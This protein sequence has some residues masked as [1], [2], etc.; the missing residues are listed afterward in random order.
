MFVLLTCCGDAQLL[1]RVALNLYNFM[2]GE[3][4]SQ[5]TYNIMKSVGI[6]LI[7]LCILNF[8][9]IASISTNTIKTHTPF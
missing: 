6:N 9:L 8:H 4:P 3:I 1:D 2:R 7:H 5:N